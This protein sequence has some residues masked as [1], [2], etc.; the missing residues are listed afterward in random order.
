MADE[1]TPGLTRDP[2]GASAPPDVDTVRD[3]KD[4]VYPFFESYTLILE[5]VVVLFL[6][7]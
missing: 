1:W 5:C 6:V 3:F 2:H 4:T 7:V